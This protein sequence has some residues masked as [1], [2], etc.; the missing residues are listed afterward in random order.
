MLCIVEAM[1]TMNHIESPY[2]GIVREVLLEN[3]MPVEIWT[4]VGGRSKRL[5]LS[6]PST[7]DDAYP[8]AT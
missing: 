1:K 3:G 7:H 8:Q 5:S 6:F 2:V 4:R